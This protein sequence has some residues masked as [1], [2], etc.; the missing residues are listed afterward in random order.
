MIGRQLRVLATSPHTA[1]QSGVA[2]FISLMRRRLRPS[3]I[4]ERLVIGRSPREVG[5]PLVRLLSDYFRFTLRVASGR[6]DVIHLDPSLTVKSTL[7][8][9]LFLEVPGRARFPRCG[10]GPLDSTK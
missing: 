5:V 9:A 1:S 8:D 7:R 10:G 3:T 2:S 6:H 4:V